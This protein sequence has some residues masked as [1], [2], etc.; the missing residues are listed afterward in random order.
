MAISPNMAPKVRPLMSCWRKYSIPNELPSPRSRHSKRGAS[1]H[2]LYGHLTHAI[3]G[4][5][6]RE[7]R[8]ASCPCE[9]L[10]TLLRTLCCKFHARTFKGKMLDRGSRSSGCRAA[11]A[12][13]ANERDCV[14]FVQLRIVREHSTTTG[15]RC[16]VPLVA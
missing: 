10:R 3:A 16:Q 2:I 14:I 11:A 15:P 5:Q 4:L 9:F 7:N 8:N 13:T 1:L 12:S 6:Q